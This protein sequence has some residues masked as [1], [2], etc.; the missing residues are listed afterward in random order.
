MVYPPCVC[1]AGVPSTARPSDEQILEYAME[2]KTELVA[3]ALLHYPDL[4]HVQDNVSDLCYCDEE[5]FR[6]LCDSQL[7]S[8]R[9]DIEDTCLPSP[10]IHHLHSIISSATILL[11]SI[12]QKVIR[13]PPYERPIFS[14]T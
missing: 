10:S 9:G 11:F 5:C 2:G 4:V 14:M 3:E 6:S 13:F 12:S 1:C 8:S 7:C